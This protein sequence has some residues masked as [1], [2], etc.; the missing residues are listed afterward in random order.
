MRLKSLFAIALFTV[1][2]TAFGYWFPARVNVVVLPGQVAAEVFNPFF[3]PI[4][5]NGQVFGQTVHG[6][7]FT[8][9]FAEQFLPIG[10]HRFAFVQTTPYAPFVHG[11]TNIHCRYFW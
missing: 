5:C 9:Y 10:G 1:T 2:T 4:I 3:Q 8:S 11:W 6:A 7:V